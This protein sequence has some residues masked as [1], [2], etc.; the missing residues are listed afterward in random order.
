MKKGQRNP[1]KVERTPGRKRKAVDNTGLLE[2]QKL[3]KN[4]SGKRKERE[5]AKEEVIEDQPAVDTGEAVVVA[6][7]DVETVENEPV[8][9][10]VDVVRKKFDKPDMALNTDSDF[11]SWKRR[12]T[13]L[14]VTVDHVV[15]GHGLHE[16]GE[17]G[18][19]SDMTPLSISERKE[20]GL[21]LKSI[22]NTNNV[23]CSKNGGTAVGVQRDIGG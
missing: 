21:N 18:V 9:N 22:V 16:K 13:S 12:R 7:G 20:R 17:Q 23:N 10:H 8:M 2:M 6:V 19:G 11:D 5:K 14:Q 1:R 4:W 15:V 3:M